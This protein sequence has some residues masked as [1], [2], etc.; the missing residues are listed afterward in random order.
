MYLLAILK[1]CNLQH[2]EI[3][4][5]KLHLCLNMSASATE[6]MTKTNDIK[7]T[8]LHPGSMAEIMGL[9][10]ANGATEDVSRFLQDAVTNVHPPIS[11]SVNPYGVVVLCGTKLT[12]EMHIELA[13]IFG[14]LDDV[15]PYVVAGRK[16]RLKY[17]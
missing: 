15:K 10:F 7:L 5:S 16:N 4:T 17:E 14:E 6:I 2:Q 11:P 8:E 3:R 12:D 13:R 9:G 1:R